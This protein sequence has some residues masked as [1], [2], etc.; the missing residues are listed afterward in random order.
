MALCHRDWPSDSIYS[1]AYFYNWCLAKTTYQWVSK[2]DGDMV[3]MDW[4]GPTVRPLLD[5]YD[6]IKILGVNIAGEHLDQLSTEPVTGLH[7]QFFRVRKDI[8][9][10]AGSFAKSFASPNAFILDL[11]RPSRSRSNNRLLCISNGLNPWP[12]RPKPGPLIGKKFRFFTKNWAEGIWDRLSRRVSFGNPR[13]DGTKEN[14]KRKFGSS[15][16]SERR[17]GII[18]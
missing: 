2:W 17:S 4:L 15:Q 10:S 7:P 14:P 5:R 1:R 9:L 16:Y 3:A 8:S 11:Y 12:L 18:A 6:I 13:N